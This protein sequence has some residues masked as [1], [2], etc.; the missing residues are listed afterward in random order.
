MKNW[1]LVL[2]L[3]LLLASC[4]SRREPSAPP[5]RPDDPQLLHQTVKRLTDVIVYDIFTPPVASRIYAY[6]SLAAYEAGRF[7]EKNAASIVK[8]LNGF[9]PMPQPV[10]GQTYAYP[11]AGLKAFLTVAH[12]LTFSKDTLK[13]FEGRLIE[14]LKGGLDKATLQRSL[15]FGEKMA[16]AILERASK[17][18]YKETR[19]M[20]RYNVSQ[21][22]GFWQPTSPDYMDA[23]EPHW[24]K[25]QPL[26][27]DSS[28][29]CPAEAPIAF[30]TAPTS[31]Y[32]KEV[33][34]VYEIGNALTDEQKAIARF[35]DDNALVSHH[36]GHATF[37]TKKMTPGGHWISIAAQASRQAKA[38]WV[39]SARAYA[40]TATALFDGF[41]A[42][43]D[44]KYRRQTLRPVTLINEKL[45]PRWE[46]FLQTPP[47]PEYP[48]GH[49]VISAA[50]AEVLTNLYGAAYAFTDKSELEYG[51]GE[52]RFSSFRAAAEEACISRLYG[53]IHYRSSCFRAATQGKRV[54]ER[55]LGKVEGN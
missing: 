40:L 24:G 21:Q 37:D 3:S 4:E 33:R 30:G 7:D 8:K 28:A 12:R 41:I 22:T 18:R 19:G 47:F 38:G 11:V 44:E 10:T 17:D 20:E 39:P 48:S 25:M 29:Q 9:G 26:A 23:V 35:W 36:T 1:L 55:V 27:L 49:S 16:L 46:S 50:A 15:D 53:G 14:R 54:G 5:P 34:E 45:D 42:C 52:R 51:M 32:W 2:L 13:Q 6:A 43:W 31:P